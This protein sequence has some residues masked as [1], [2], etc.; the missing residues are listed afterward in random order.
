MEISSPIQNSGQCKSYCLFST[1]SQLIFS[2]TTQLVGGHENQ[3]KQSLEEKAMTKDAS[4]C[5]SGMGTT[6]LPD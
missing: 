2:E 1:I 5:V 6:P 4:W 3:G